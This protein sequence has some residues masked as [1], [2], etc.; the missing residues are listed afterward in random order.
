MSLQAV[1]A[2]LF[3]QVLLTF[4]LL[5]MMGRTRFAAAK[6]GEVRFEDIALGQSAWPERPTKVANA[7][8][9]QFEMPVLFYVLVIL[10]VITRKADLLFVVLSW[11]F[12]LTRL[13]HALIHTGSN[14]VMRRFTAFVAG[15][16]VLAAMWVVFAAR[17]L[18]AL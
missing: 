9:N 11:V 4:V 17:I 3:V 14:V 10:A 5:M 16:A 8:S 12:V 15:V 18:L 13:V 1:L 7:F 6:A 2:P